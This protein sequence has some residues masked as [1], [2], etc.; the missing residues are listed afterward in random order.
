M[1]PN[2]HGVP[3]RSF[4][5]VAVACASLVPSAGVRA[6]E[7]SPGGSDEVVLSVART[8]TAGAAVAPRITSMRHRW[9]GDVQ[10][11]FRLDIRFSQDVTGFTIGDIE[12]FG[13][14]PDPPLSP[15]GSSDRSYYLTMITRDDYQGPVIIEIPADAAENDAGEGNIA[16]TP[17]IFDADTRAPVADDAEVDGRELVVTFS[18]GLDESTIPSVGNFDVYVTRDGDRDDERVSRVEVDATEVILTLVRA[19]RFGD[20]VELFYDDAG[21]RALRDEAGNL[22]RPFDLRVENDTDEGEAPGPPRG[23]TADADGASVIELNWR[24]PLD[25]GSSAIIGYLIEVSSN[26]GDT[27]SSRVRDTGSTATRYRHTRLAPN[28][29]RHYRVSAINSYDA[30]APSN[31]DSATTEVPAPDAP[32]R[33]TAR[34]RGTSTIDLDWTAPPS[35]SAAPITGYRIEVSPTGNSRWTALE[36]DTDSRTTDYTHTGLNPG[37]KRYYR[38]SAINSVGRSNPSNVAHATTDVTA[39][40]APSGLSAVPS[41]LGEA[42]SSSS[43]GR[44]R[45]RTAG[46]RSAATGLK[47]P[48]TASRIGP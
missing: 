3:V 25:G 27:W 10:E 26:E 4:L 16:A 24:A 28:T 31:V 46:A 19:V 47:C 36:A 21:T 17:Y 38:V 41:G 37:T 34:A 12:V 20:V 18:E 40:G 7:P 43:P 14:E 33:L 2:K 29:T 44:A 22:A 32:T 45:P 1:I 23:L 5:A 11:E 13:A 42:A 48:P 6:Q 35:V 39:P 15:V 8:A 30:G 9:T